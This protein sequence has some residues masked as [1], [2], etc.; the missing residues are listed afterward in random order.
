MKNFKKITII[1]IVSA[2]ALLSLVL[3]SS[4]NNKDKTDFQYELKS[5]GTY[6]IVGIG[7]IKDTDI[8][9]PSTH[10]GKPITSIG[11]S[12][13][14]ENNNI[15]SVVIP[16]NIKVEQHAFYYCKSIVQIVIGKNVK[17]AED[18]FLGCDKLI[19]ACINSDDITI[20]D[21]AIGNIGYYAL[22]IYSS[23]SGKSNI[24]TTLD[25]YIFYKDD[26]HCYLIGYKGNYDNLT[27]P[28]S[29]NGEEYE[30]YRY[31]FY[32]NKNIK[33][34]VIPDSV[35]TMGIMTFACCSNLENVTIGK[36]LREISQGAFV[37]CSSLETITIPSNIEL[38]GH[39]A[40]ANCSNLT[41]A[42]FENAGNWHVDISTFQSDKYENVTLSDPKTAAEYL[43]N[44]YV[45]YIFIKS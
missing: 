25:G 15:T 41:S 35:K 13:F 10:N 16:E 14:S 19:E 31:A 18:A 21:E 43:T 32:N 12:A 26:T 22:N 17:L 45:N 23:E 44:I 34:I 30:I 29:Y 36:G 2:L 24:S 5:D 33:S 11:V 37:E 4:C 9:I 6:K 38:I 27:L 42:T 20:D 1:L 3:L 28:E 40:F 7:T 8:V 39:R